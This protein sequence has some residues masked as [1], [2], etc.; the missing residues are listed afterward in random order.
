M[1]QAPATTKGED[2]RQTK[3]FRQWKGCFTQASRSS[4]PQDRWYNLEN[5]IPIGDANIHS[6]PDKSAVLVDYG[7]DVIYWSTYVNLN[8]VDYLIQ[9]ANNGKV[10]AYNIGSNTSTRIDGGTTLSGSGSR[11]A[12][13]KNSQVLIIDSSGYYHW[14]G[15]TFALISGAGVP[16]AGVDIAVYAGRVWIA[17]ARILFF[18]AADDYTA[19]AWTAANGSGFVNLTDS[20]LRS[21]IQRLWSQNG[22]LYIIGISS[23]NAISDVY[24]PSGASPPTPVFTNLNIQALIGSD[25]PASVFAF[26]RLMMFATRY[27]VYALYGVSAQR[28]SADIDGTWQYV[29]FSQSVS[30]GAVQVENILNAAFLIKRANDPTFGSN[31][32]LAMWFTNSDGSDS[33]WWFGN[34][35]ALTF[36]TSAMVGAN[37][38]LFGFIGNKLYQLYANAATAP[39][40]QLMTPLWDMGEPLHDK[41]VIRAGFEMGISVFGNPVSMTVDTINSQFAAVT[42]SNPGL[43]S[44]VNNSNQI[45]LWQ[46][47]ALAIVG[48][49]TGSF[50]LYNGAAPGTFGPYVGCT[51]TVGSGNVF[52]FDA[53]YMDYKLRAR[54]HQ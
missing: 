23:I 6:V 32:V 19:T 14:D 43:T 45:V 42:L 48:W 15:V 18:S 5:A 4:L 13:W 51:I 2:P 29:N 40:A 7:L 39:A 24:V 44:W 34:Y 38:S 10:F 36:I 1:A 3:Q 31:T 49:F 54:W 50:L 16:T 20:T 41:Q 27:G 28:L 25:Q 11:A 8:N 9:F 37:P 47:N 30:G 26:D 12:Q 35:G 33:R 52:Q 53:V 21:A 22:Y 46:N 17:Q